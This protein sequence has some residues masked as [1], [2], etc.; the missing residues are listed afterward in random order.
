MTDTLQSYRQD[1]AIK[2]FSPKMEP[3]RNNDPFRHPK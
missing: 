2:G 3:V 1:L